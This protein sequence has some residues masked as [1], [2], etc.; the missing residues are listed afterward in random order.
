MNS[1][2]SALRALAFAALTVSLAHA[3]G[4]SYEQHDLVSD[5]TI[6]AD[7]TD[8]NL[9]N[10]WGLAFGPTTPAWVAD[11]RTGVSTLY[12]GLG[13]PQ[14]L[15][16]AIPSP[17]GDSGGSPTGIVFNGN[18]NDFVVSKG[19][20][21]GGSAFI[22]ATEDGVI[23]GWSPG[24]DRTHAIRAVTRPDTVYKGLAIAPNGTA[25]FLYAADFRNGKIDVFDRTFHL[26]N[27][28]GAF[29][30]PAM[31]AGFAPFN[32]QNIQGN[33]YVAYAKQDEAKT[34]NLKGAGL[35]F[36]DVFDANGVLIHRVASRGKLNAPWGL[37][38]APANFGKF[39][40]RLLV[41]N[42][43]DGAVLA[44]DA[45][46]HE[47]VGRLRKPDGQLL[48]IDGLWA[49]VFGNGAQHQPTSTLFFTA[50]PDEENHGL[51]GTI[52]P[53]P[54]G[55]DDEGDDKDD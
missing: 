47:F 10:A 32:I 52:T 36:V 50:G 34:D 1:L 39:S 43:G 31:P 4:N 40:N 17:T 14:A 22:F 38:L 33:L 6:A 21:S 35:G 8:R 37:A 7:H 48:K 9:V 13:N 44:F 45:H 46:S 51:Y 2:R 3:A 27:A 26:V 49:L 55:A 28:P 12:D 5:G 18:T 41:G 29:R 24:V 11:N 54:G 30:D 23:A 42:F 53:A 19:G 16:V 15:V 25:S 20:A